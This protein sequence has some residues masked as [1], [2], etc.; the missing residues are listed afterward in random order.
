MQKIHRIRCL[1]VG[2]GGCRFWKPSVGI[3]RVAHAFEKK[4]E[5]FHGSKLS[6]SL[7]RPFQRDLP[8]MEITLQAMTFLLRQPEIEGGSL[9][10]SLLRPQAAISLILALLALAGA[11]HTSHQ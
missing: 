5:Y 10:S 8:R 9:Q 4:A 6:T 11:V 3:S 1:I 2:A 7:I